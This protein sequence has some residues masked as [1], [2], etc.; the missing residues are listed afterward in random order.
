M[1]FLRCTVIF[2]AFVIMPVAAMAETPAT[3]PSQKE[4]VEAE[5]VR[6][7][8]RGNDVTPNPADE[9]AVQKRITTF[10][11]TQEIQDES[12]DKKLSI[13]RGC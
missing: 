4:Q 5:S 7:Q 8:P 10:N 9:D 2:Y 1:R 12:F 3:P 11:S 6:V 13:C